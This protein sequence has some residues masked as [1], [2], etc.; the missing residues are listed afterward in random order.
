MA[1]AAPQSV[2][3]KLVETAHR[4]SRASTIYAALAILTALVY[5]RWALAPR[6]LVTF[7]AINFALAIDDF[8]PA[9][10]Q[11][12]P[13]GYPLF[14]GL[15]KILSFIPD[16]RV[17]FL[18]AAILVSVAALMLTWRVADAM[19]G[20]G[21]GGVAVVLL[22]WNPP[23]WLSA[24]TNPVRL[25]LAMG[26][27]AVALCVWN[28]LRR[29]SPAWLIAAA[30][31]AGLAAGFRPMVAV[32]MA[33]LIVWAALRMRI[34]WKS[35][36]LS[37]LA[38]GLAVC[39][40]L[41]VLIFQ[42]G[43]VH[44]FADMLAGYSN[45][46]IA[47]TS[48]L[49][50]A[51]LRPVAAMAWNG[52][53]WSCLGALSWMWLVPSAWKSRFRKDG[54][55][56]RFLAVWFFSGLV[57]HIAIHVADPDHTLGTVVA[58]CIAGALVIRRASEQAS[59]RRR[60]ILVGAAAALNVLLFL[61]PISKTAKPSTYRP[62]QWLDTYISDVIEGSRRLLAE[63]PVTAI[64]DE[65]VTGWRQLSYY[66]PRV[67]IMVLSPKRDLVEVRRIRGRRSEIQLVSADAIPVPSCG[68]LAWVDPVARP[69]GQ[70]IE[71]L[72]SRI[73]FSRVPLQPAV[74]FRQYRL[75][76]TREGCQG[77]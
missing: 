71:Y 54:L 60:V 3:P 27:A 13:P 58:T 76:P 61:K 19:L 57:S 68:T 63:G 5:S 7:D 23:F 77:P 48:V 31:I 50:G 30:A 53:V 41:S 52:I 55:V 25:T 43:G 69:V 37:L 64:F 38:F 74:R 39:S 9:L 59:F 14:V 4:T 12:Q 65:P 66:V 32:R 22:L 72:N 44:R 10:H 51:S 15:L 21:W 8:N 34:G 29:A 56:W 20:Q 6:Y 18:T 28:A 33:P 62:V 26:A 24:L 75:V 40:W 42:C 2:A 11:P 47:P 46:Q 36:C 49:F 17:L 70:P 1:T 16:I 45:Q 67:H 35:A 73:V